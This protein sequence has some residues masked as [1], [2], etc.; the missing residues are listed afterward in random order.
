[1]DEIKKQNPVLALVRDLIFSSRISSTARANGVEIKILRDPA[2]LADETGNLLLVDLNQPGALEAAAQWK[3]NS[4]RQVVGFVSHVDSLI[5]SQ[6]RSTGIDKI[7]ARSQFV[8]VLPLLLS[9]ESLK[10]SDKQL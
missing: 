1:M 10:L 7:L 2:Q 3:D 8:Q 6:A 5:I 4:R 9:G